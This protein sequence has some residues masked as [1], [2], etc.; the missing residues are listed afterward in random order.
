MPKQKISFWTGPCLVKQI[1]EAMRKAGLR[2]VGEGTEHVYL[3]VEEASDEWAA[4]HN[5]LAV[6]DGQL[7]HHFGLRAPGNAWAQLEVRNH[8]V[9]RDE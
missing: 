9:D 8:G 5:A 3:T 7:G 1:A 4:K 2:D 6:L